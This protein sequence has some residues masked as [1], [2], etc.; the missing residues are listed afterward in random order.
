MELAGSC[1]GLENYAYI[2]LKF[3]GQG[4]KDSA[5]YQVLPGEGGDFTLYLAQKDADILETGLDAAEYAFIVKNG[6]E[7]IELPANLTLQ[8]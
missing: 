2:Y 7:Y 3:T 6:N 1:S 4:A 8:D 5:V